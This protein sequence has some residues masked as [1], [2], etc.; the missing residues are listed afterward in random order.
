MAEGFAA[1][2]AQA[3][4]ALTRLVDCIARL[5]RLTQPG[6]HDA[7]HTRATKARDAFSLMM[8]GDLN[9][10]GALG[11][12]F[13]LVRDRNAAI[14]AGEVGTDDVP[15]LKAAFASFDNVLGVIGLRQDEDATPPVPVDEI[16][17]LIEARQ[18]A[19]RRRDFAAADQIRSDLESRGIV[20]EDS[21][22]GTRWKR[23]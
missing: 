5:D 17:Q 21:P 14:D 16:D 23:K 6:S 7:I 9:T 4:E 11:V 18:A 10:P 8:L 15:A 22:S 13:E 1:A 12:V 3:E 2:L 19:R 20:L